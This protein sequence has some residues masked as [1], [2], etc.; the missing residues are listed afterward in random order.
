M[1]RKKQTSNPIVLS[2]GS[3]DDGKGRIVTTSDGRKVKVD[4]LASSEYWRRREA[5]QQTKNIR[6]EQKIGEEMKKIYLRMFRESQTQIDAFYQR[7]AD[8]NGITLA[9][10]RKR[11]SQMDINAYAAKAKK[12]VMDRDLSD[13]AN[14]EMALYNLTMKVNRLEMLKAEM[15]MALVDGFEEMSGIIDRE[16]TERA[17]SEYERKAGILGKT[18]QNP[19]AKAAAIVNA[20]FHN[21]TWSER[22]WSHQEALKTE[23]GRQLM[24]GLIAGKSSRDMA[25]EIRKIFGGSLQNAQRLMVTELARVQTEA[26]RQSMEAN[27]NTEYEYM[28]TGPHPCP[29]CMKLD[30]K[31]FKI[32]EMQV[33][34]NAPPLHPSCH[35]CTAPYVG[36]EKYKRWL[37]ALERGEDVRWRD[38]EE[39]E[40]RGEAEES[41]KATP[42]E[43]GVDW[44]KVQAPEYRNALEKIISDQKAVDA[45]LTRARWA[46]NNRDGK[47][48][49]EIYAVSLSNGERREISRITNQSIPSGVKRTKSFTRKLNEADSLGESILLLHNHP[50]GMPPSISDINLLKKNKNVV[51]I[52]VGHDGS[53]YFYTRPE[54][55]ITDEDFRLAVSNY[56][57]YSEITATEKALNELSVSHGFKVMK[58]R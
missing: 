21:A 54:K 32:R 56:A 43:C 23:I 33:G 6:D 27:G 16:L 35:C 42:G 4:A 53:I 9:E 30:G 45:V 18:V 17:M 19:A 8:K 14:E 34:V 26:A 55:I 31:V 13:Q 3:V 36:G 12:Y 41:R 40:E 52:T 22:L 50:R 24:S 11:V 48:T 25:R 20:S 1:A 5:R 44:P 37:E 38:F 10:A 2:D 47:E 49:E 39:W 46:L 28:A 7:Y 51:G 15:G 29:E 58:L 57:R